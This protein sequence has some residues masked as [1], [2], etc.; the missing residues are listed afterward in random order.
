[1]S[2]T[3]DGLPVVDASPYVSCV[4]VW[5]ARD[6]SREFLVLHRAHEGP[7]SVGD[8]A[9]TPP[10]GARMPG[11]T[12][13]QAA[14][15]ELREETGLALAIAPRAGTP[16][17]DVA[18]YVAEAPTDA[19]VMLDAEHDTFLWLPVE[20]AVKKCLPAQ[21]GICVASAAASLGPAVTAEDSGDQLDERERPVPSRRDEEVLAMR[22]REQ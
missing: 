12:P 17:Q 1:M 18:L 14:K 4:V 20:E 10:S 22:G 7:D 11:E 13:D 9:W 19:Q 3:W 5:R 2:V 16:S 8:W 21:V 15:R 6:G